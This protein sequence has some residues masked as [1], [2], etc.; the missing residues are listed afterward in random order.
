MATLVQITLKTVDAIPENFITNT[1]AVTGDVVDAGDY[2]DLMACFK[3][4]YD[5]IRGAIFPSTI[6][7]NNHEFKLYI[8]G[9]P[10]PNYPIYENVWNLASAPSGNPLPSEVALCLSFAGLRVPGFAQA[11]R[12]GRVYLGPCKDTLNSAGRPVPASITAIL[13]AAQVLRDDIEDVPSAGSWAVWS[14]TN[15]SAV[16]LTDAWMDNAWDTQRSRGLIRTLKTTVPLV[17]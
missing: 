16:A 4:F 10:R 1:F 17:P 14:P 12:R 7:M 9:G 13:A 5:A 2:A 8:A 3:T 6:A 15:G 11:R